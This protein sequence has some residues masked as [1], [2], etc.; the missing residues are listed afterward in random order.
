MYHWHAGM[1]QRVSH[2]NY[3]RES[4]ATLTHM[5]P[6]QVERA[7]VPSDSKV[8]SSNC[9]RK[10]ISKGPFCQGHF[11]LQL[12]QK[13]DM[14][15]LAGCWWWSQ[16]VRALAGKDQLDHEKFLS[17]T[18][19]KT[20]WHLCLSL[21]RK[22]DTFCLSRHQIKTRRMLF[23]INT[24]LHKLFES[25]S[26]WWLRSEGTHSSPQLKFLKDFWF[27]CP[28]R[29]INNNVSSSLKKSH[30]QIGSHHDGIIV[31][32]L[33]SR[34]CMNDIIDACCHNG[35]TNNNAVKL[36]KL[37]PIV[38][39]CESSAQIVQMW[40]KRE[41]HRRLVDVLL[42]SR[43]LFITLHLTCEN[44]S[45]GLH[46]LVM[47]HTGRKVKVRNVRHS[48]SLFC[49]KEKKEAHSTL[50]RFSASCDPSKSDPENQWQSLC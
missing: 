23:S 50:I 1:A 30:E 32:V 29:K 49:H 41:V 33:S 14:H 36:I 5:Q 27:A 8:P 21:L 35:F 22:N 12:H 44:C 9:Q 34:L 25:L 13:G 47:S 46:L 24:E 19:S 26:N 7:H 6:M 38:C 43:K 45:A 31:L 16:F 18:K 48:D 15:V 10:G 42:F 3:R 11:P 2:A 4:M 39:T 17:T 40:Q 37:H 20:F 28:V